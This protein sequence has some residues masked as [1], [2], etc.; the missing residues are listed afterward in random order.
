MNIKR[1]LRKTFKNTV[2]SFEPLLILAKIRV[3]TLFGKVFLGL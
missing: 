3:L 2:N 1:L